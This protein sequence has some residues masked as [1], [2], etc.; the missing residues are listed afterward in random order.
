MRRFKEALALLIQCGRSQHTDGAREHG[1]FIGKDVAEKI[2][3]DH[4]IDLLRSLNQLHGCVVDIHMFK[5]DFR[6]FF[7]DL[8][9]RVAP[10]LRSF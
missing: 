2:A 4:H 5:G 3:C 7:A 6:I 9:H 10:H 1:G 8:D